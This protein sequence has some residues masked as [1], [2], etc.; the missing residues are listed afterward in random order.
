[1]SI[2]DVEIVVFGA[3]FIY[4]LF[5]QPMI[6]VYRI[7]VHAEALSAIYSLCSF[8]LWEYLFRGFDYNIS[9]H[10]YTQASYPDAVLC[11]DRDS[12][13]EKPD[14]SSLG[15]QWT[16]QVP[17]SVECASP[18]T[19][20]PVEAIETPAPVA[21]I[22]RAP[23]TQEPTAS[24]APTDCYARSD[25]TN[26][27]VIQTVGKDVILPEDAVI[28]AT[29]DGESLEV[30]VNNLWGEGAKVFLGYWS[31]GLCTCLDEPV[32][33]EGSA[34]KQAMCVE[35]VAEIGV[36]VS[37]SSGG[38]ED[39]CGEC[40]PPEIDS[41]FAVSYKFALSCGYLCA[42]DSPTPGPTPSLCQARPRNQPLGQPLGQPR[43]PLWH[44]L[45]NRLLNLPRSDS[46]THAWAYPRIDTKTNSGANAWTY[47]RTHSWP[48]PR[49]DTRAPG[50]TPEPTPGPTPEP[51][52]RPS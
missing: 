44:L 18:P 21:R 34:K 16:F 36:F 30:V 41:D 20:A 25:I 31:A 6:T 4:D 38:D 2:C 52:P 43:N 8:P 13:S 15:A 26:G 32:E 40:N 1:M 14:G 51:T 24:P 42:T 10:S 50:P 17:C 39:L 3:E 37:Y 46:R 7:V 23:V 49:T 27:D 12:D 22:T 35:G 9:H 19:R 11:T 5:I 45:P 29:V 28:V 48:Y 47:T 33:Y